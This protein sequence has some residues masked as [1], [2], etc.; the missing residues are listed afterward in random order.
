MGD[1]LGRDRRLL[2]HLT[3]REYFGR[4]WIVPEF[5]IAR[6]LVL[7]S[8]HRLLSWKS[9]YD[10]QRLM[11]ERNKTCI[12]M[13]LCSERYLPEASTDRCE[14]REKLN[15]YATS[16]CSDPRDAVFALLSIRINNAAGRSCWPGILA[17]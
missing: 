10:M 5:I 15:S 2:E 3:S 17:R 13:Q 7:Y 14:L 8:G 11:L 16:K 12:A 1:N 6:Q 4:R 9:L